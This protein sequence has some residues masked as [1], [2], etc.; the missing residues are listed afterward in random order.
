MTLTTKPGKG[1]RFY[2]YCDDE[3]FASVTADMWYSLGVT[4][5]Q[6]LDDESYKALRNEIEGRQAYASAV[7]MLTMRAHARK[8]LAVKLSRKFGRDAV[9]YALDKCASLGFL[10]DAAFAREYAGGLRERKRLA[11]NRIR[12]ELAACSEAWGRQE[13]LLSNHRQV[14][15]G[16][17]RAKNALAHSE[18]GWR[19]LDRLASLAMG[20]IS[21]EGRLSFDRYVMG[22]VFRE[23]LE[24][25]NRRMD[26]MSGGRY[27]LIHRSDADRKNARAG[28]EIQVLDLSTG[29]VRGSDSLSGG[30]GFFTSLSLA[31]G[32]AD[33]VQNRAGG[34]NLDALFID[35]GFGSLSQGVL[36]TAVDVLK[37]LSKGQRLVGIIS[38]VAQLEECITQKIRV[39]GGGEGS[40]L[41]LDP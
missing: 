25:A 41:T 30:E 40:S 17:E 19:R 3:Y 22:A 12:Q 10:D 31:L 6:A 8:E 27:Q 34:H 33:T 35:E 7:R 26:I 32:P 16:A 5:G 18:N 23:I 2:L 38:H 21:D 4:E 14:L 29:R 11:P 37:E 28:L 15:S 39:R 20:A 24:M 13:N 1:G 9:E 36:E